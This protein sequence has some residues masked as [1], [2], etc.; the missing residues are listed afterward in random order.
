MEQLLFS[1]GGTGVG[2]AIAW[3]WIKSLREDMKVLR[4]D[5][6]AQLAAIHAEHTVEIKCL[7]DAHETEVTRIQER[8]DRMQE[9]QNELFARA[10]KKTDLK[11]T[12]H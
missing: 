2:L 7:T 11:D 8:L 12:D 4:E 9:R 10:L 6:K 5:H 3:Y 1:L